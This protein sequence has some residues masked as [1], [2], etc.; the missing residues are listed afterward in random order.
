[1]IAKYIFKIKLPF[2]CIVNIVAGK[3]IYP[4][5]YGFRPD[6]KKASSILKEINDNK[7]SQENYKKKTYLL[8]EAFERENEIKNPINEILNYLK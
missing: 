3:Q 7:N 4:E 5:F 1:L 2:Y 8:R 6:K